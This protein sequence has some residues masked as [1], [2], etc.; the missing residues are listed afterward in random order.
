MDSSPT[1]TDDQGTLSDLL[2]DS[3]RRQVVSRLAERGRN[4]P[5]FLDE[6]SAELAELEEGVDESV[7]TLAIALHHN[8][9]PKLDEAGLIEYDPIT[10][11]VTPTFRTD[12]LPA[13]GL[14][15]VVDS[16]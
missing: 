14:E 10:H 2:A 6:L 9:L 15:A 13:S 11:M 1:T 16:N 4:R 3:R 8:H 12:D 7:D 5:I